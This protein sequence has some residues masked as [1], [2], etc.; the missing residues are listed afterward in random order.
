M[1]A[2]DICLGIGVYVKNQCLLLT[3]L[4]FAMLHIIDGYWVAIV[5]TIFVSV[6]FFA[7]FLPYSI[8]KYLLYHWY[9]LQESWLRAAE[10][11]VNLACNVANQQ[12]GVDTTGC[13]KVDL[14]NNEGLWILS[15]ILAWSL[16]SNYI[17]NVK[18]NWILHYLT[19]H[20]S[21]FDLFLDSCEVLSV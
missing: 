5:L 8:C 15:K 1:V 10:G 2:M 17:A 9:K 7:V 16:P 4:I 19:C 21:F 12:S 14:H 18:I 6:S 13:D 11:L 20:Y 3:W